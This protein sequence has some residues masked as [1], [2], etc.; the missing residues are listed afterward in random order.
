MPFVEKQMSSILNPPLH[1]NCFIVWLD[2]LQK[3]SFCFHCCYDFFPMA[4]G[5]QYVGWQ[6]S[7]LLNP[8]LHYEHFTISLN[9]LQKCSTEDSLLNYKCLL[10]WSLC[11][12]LNTSHCYHQM[13]SRIL[14]SSFNSWPVFLSVKLDEMQVLSVLK[15]ML[16]CEHFNVALCI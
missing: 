4:G 2:D 10:T 14:L 7:S 3:H 12:T 13:T 8:L 5:N 9:D 11:C 15:A 1:C 16:S 6:M